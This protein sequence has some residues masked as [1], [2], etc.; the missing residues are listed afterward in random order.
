MRTLKIV[1]IFVCIFT[2]TLYSQFNNNSFYNNFTN[3]SIINNVQSDIVRFYDVGLHLFK[4]PL[5]FNKQDFYLTSAILG[6]TAVSLPFDEPIRKEALRNQSKPLDKISFITEKFGN[7]K[8]SAILSG[9]LYGSGLLLDD[10]YIRETGQML[11][12]ALLFNGLIT[13]GAKMM[14]SRGRPFTNEGSY[15]I[16]LFEFESNFK[17]TS[18]PSGHTS[19]AFTAATILSNRIDNMYVSIALYS[20][21]SL[22]ALQRIYVDRHWFSDTILGAALGTV[23]GLKVIKLHKP[24]SSPKEG[25]QY[26]IYP[27]FQS[28]NIGV[29]LALQF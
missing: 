20:M 28:G 19:T 15:E 5:Q 18:L 1:F 12:E 11:A 6:L 4:S 21:A 2:S 22:T 27:Y 9:A 7:P 10:K 13:T 16:D 3:S 14:F 17:E 8:Y 24:H 25:F 23:I 26:N 29:G